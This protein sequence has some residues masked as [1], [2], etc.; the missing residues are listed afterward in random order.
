[1]TFCDAARIVLKNEK[2]KIRSCTEY[3]DCFSFRLIPE[4]MEPH[5]RLATG[6]TIIRKA[7]SELIFLSSPGALMYIKEKETIQTWDYMQAE[8]ALKA[9]DET[10]EGSCNT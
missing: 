6:R 1:M 10:N 4:E 9:E 3:E 2:L 8:E 5:T 7:D